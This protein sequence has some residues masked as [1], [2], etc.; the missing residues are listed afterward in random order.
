MGNPGM[1]CPWKVHGEDHLVQD[2]NGPTTTH[3]QI[4]ALFVDCPPARLK[5]KGDQPCQAE[6][7]YIGSV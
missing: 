4:N 1:G 5:S 6:S 2:A 3:V 7:G